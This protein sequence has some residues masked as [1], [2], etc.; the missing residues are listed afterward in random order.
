MIPRAAIALLLLA[1]APAMTDAEKSARS[2][3]FSF[4]LAP[5]QT[6]FHGDWAAFVKAKEAE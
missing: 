3:W 1:G 4:E 2:K 6:T 5:V